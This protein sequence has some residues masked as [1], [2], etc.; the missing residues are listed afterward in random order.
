MEQQHF[1]RQR[2][3]PAPGRFAGLTGDDNSF[4]I[5][6]LPSTIFD[7]PDTAAFIDEERH[8]LD[9]SPGNKSDRYDGRL[10]LDSRVLRALEDAS[11][12]AGVALEEDPELHAELELER[13]RDLHELQATQTADQLQGGDG[14]R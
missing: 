3:R 5:L 2:R 13:W 4:L 1:H 9:V 11:L 12:S 6:G 8:L 10:L 14:E 7:D